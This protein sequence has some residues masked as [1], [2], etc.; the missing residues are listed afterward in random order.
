MGLRKKA[1]IF[2][3]SCFII[4]VICELLPHYRTFNIVKWSIYGFEVFAVSTESF[5]C[6]RYFLKDEL[7]SIVSIIKRLFTKD[8]Q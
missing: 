8:R 1:V 3:A 2:S 7:K 4:F 5:L 6:K